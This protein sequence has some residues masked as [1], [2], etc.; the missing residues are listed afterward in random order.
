MKTTIPTLDL[1]A[2]R[3]ND[4][5]TWPSKQTVCQHVNL[6]VRTLETRYIATGKVKSVN[7]PR[8]QGGGVYAVIHPESVRAL[9]A[10][11]S[12]PKPP[13]ALEK[14]QIREERA[15]ALPAPEIDRQFAFALRWVTVPQAAQLTGLSCTH[16]KKAIRC[17]A[18]PAIRNTGYLIKLT[19]LERYTPRDDRLVRAPRA[20]ANAS[21][22]ASASAS[23]STNTALNGAMMHA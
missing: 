5:T 17:G 4:P 3:V 6:S 21:A 15:L 19:S 1:D 10:E 13:T 7:I 9:L 20:S 2:M 12:E 8:P 11:A 23:A 16:L 18:L 22:N 14:R